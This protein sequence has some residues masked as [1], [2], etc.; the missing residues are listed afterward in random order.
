MLLQD[1]KEPAGARAPFSAGRL[2]LL[3]MLL[4]CAIIAGVVERSIPV[5]FAVPGVKLGL[6]NVVILFALYRL[7]PGEVFI[8]AMLKCLLTS[9]FIASFTA[10][11]YS[12][13]GSLLSFAVMTVM[14][15]AGKNLFSPVGISVAG[16]ICH[17]I[18]Q[19]LASSF[20]LG[21]FMV[22]TYLPVLLISGVITGVIVGVAVKALIRHPALGNTLTSQKL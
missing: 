14:L 11:V 1:K 20:V 18:G 8:L 2:A 10:L 3:S 16:A 17:N 9:L 7:K 5:D 13:C 6:A 12:A 19:I 4:G 22:A 21:S 15:K